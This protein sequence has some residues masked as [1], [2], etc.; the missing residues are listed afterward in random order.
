MFDFIYRNNYFLH[1][2]FVPFAYTFVWG[3]SIVMASYDF[4]IDLSNKY[5]SPSVIQGSI[6]VYLVFILECIINIFDT[7]ISHY[8]EQFNVNFVWWILFFLSDV[9]LTIV[10]ALLYFSNVGS[11]FYLGIF[12]LLSVCLMKFLFVFMSNN[13]KTFIFTTKL[14]CITSTFNKKG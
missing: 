3:L 7:I 13:I 14:K 1:R 4:S 5:F 6:C 8:E 11:E 2:W 9:F 10:I 12:Y